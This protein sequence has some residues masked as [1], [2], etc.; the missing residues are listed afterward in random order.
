M[1]IKTKFE[2]GELELPYVWEHEIT[3]EER[4]EMINAD[5]DPNSNE[6]MAEWFDSEIWCEATKD[7]DFMAYAEFKGANM[8]DLSDFFDESALN[9]YRK[10]TKGW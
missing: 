2:V 9:F 5:Y 4:K 3:E 1:E 7:W 10:A 8:E 6:D